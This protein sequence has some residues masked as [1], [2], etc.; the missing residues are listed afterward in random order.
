MIGSHCTRPWR[1]PS[2]PTEL[3]DTNPRLANR[4][5]SSPYGLFRFVNRSFADEVCARFERRAGP[6]V[7]LHGDA[8]IEQYAVTDTGRGLADFDDA[9]RGPAAIDL[10]RMTTSLA[11]SCRA[12]GFQCESILGSFYEGYRIALEAPIAKLARPGFAKKARAT[13]LRDRRA[14]FAEREALFEP[15][16][17][18]ER[19]DH[20]L[21]H[22]RRQ[23]MRRHPELP[24]AFFEPKRVGRL[25][26]GV[27][28]AL[29]E[30]Y[31]VRI[32][33]PS[34][35]SDDDLFLELKEVRDLSGIRCLSPTGLGSPLRVL[36]GQE[37][38]AYQPY[39]LAG[40]VLLSSHDHAQRGANA[41]WVHE[42]ADNYVEAAHDG[43]DRPD[44]L[45]ELARDVGVQ[46]GLGHPRNWKPEVAADV[47]RA[48]LRWFDD[49]RDRI[50]S[51]G[52]ELAETLETT[53]TRRGSLP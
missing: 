49:E 20:I 52:I 15:L 37:R 51:L 13:F 35:G 26:I 48:L 42:W 21:F 45:A 31:L 5:E 12:N 41:F 44:A 16:K 8:H 3:A 1:V 43:F 25:R 7:N 22:Y 6:T 17:D 2:I 27:G 38:I 18:A 19:F 23:I 24:P 33:G 11:L 40:Y 34:P 9:A 46:L 4:I 30:K 29:D 32:E 53:W 36:R 10:V 28:S 39:Q 14:V 50:E 47:R